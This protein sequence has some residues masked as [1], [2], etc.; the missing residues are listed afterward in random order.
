MK[1]NRLATEL[2]TECPD[3]CPK[4][5]CNGKRFLPHEDGWQCFNCMKI[6]YKAGCE[7]R[8]DIIPKRYKHNN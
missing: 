1:I 6:I 3:I 2:N 8:E 7:I 5:G 4:P